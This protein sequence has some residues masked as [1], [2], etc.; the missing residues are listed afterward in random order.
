M[1]EDLEAELRMAL[2]EGL[3]TREEAG[4]LRE[5][6]LRL[7]KSPMAL[8]KERGVIS[9]ESLADLR[10]ADVEKTFVPRATAGG[11]A[12][13]GPALT[14]ADRDKADPAFPVPGWERYEGVRFLGQGG[15]GRVFLAYDRSLRRNVAL[16]FVK[17]DDE[18]L[19]RRL[20]SEARAQARVEHERVCQVH[21]VGEV[22]GKPY[23][24]M[25]FVDGLPLDQGASEL[26]L[27][28]EQKVLVLR[29]AA[30]GVHAAHRAGL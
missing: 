20:L 21:E 28:V 23:I 17:G 6:A 8:L 25:Q 19:V 15:M 4:A 13:L 22:Q 24:A 27:T 12:T 29:E 1:P 2:A 16:K 18:Q 14:L 10:K 3:L 9:D 11:A 26:K 30:E 7:G 5:E